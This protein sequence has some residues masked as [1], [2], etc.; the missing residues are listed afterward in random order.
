M[1]LFGIAFLAALALATATRLWLAA[2]H[3]AH[4]RAHRHSVPAEFAAEVGLEAHQKAADYTCAKTRLAMIEVAVDA[5]V[6][7]ALT[8]G[9]VLQW[10]HEVSAAWL[11]E[12]IGRGLTLLALVAALTTLADLPFGLYRTFVVEQRF[13]FNKMTLA[14]YF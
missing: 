10:L 7:L 14:M 13:G 8:F 12:G 5:A 3:L 2:R 6:L 11:T 1:H 4:V 9:G